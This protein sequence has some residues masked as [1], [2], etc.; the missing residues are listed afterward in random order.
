MLT[1]WLS[2]LINRADSGYPDS[3]ASRQGRHSRMPLSGIHR[4]LAITIPAVRG[5]REWRRAD[6][7]GFRSKL[8]SRKG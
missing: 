3:S 2:N 8:D 4:P 5:A 6:W 7:A 1:L